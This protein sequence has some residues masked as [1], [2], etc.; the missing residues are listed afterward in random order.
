MDYV[1]LTGILSKS[2]DVHSLKVHRAQVCSPACYMLSL[3]QAFNI[4]FRTL[5][6]FDESDL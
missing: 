4:Y 6:F 1:F 2:P 3:E 5:T